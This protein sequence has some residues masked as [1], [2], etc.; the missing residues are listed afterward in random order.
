[1]KFYV[2]QFLQANGILHSY[3]RKG[4]P[5][6]NAPI[7]AFHSIIKREKLNRLVLKTYEKAKTVIF[8]YI[9]GFYNRRR[10]HR[11]I[12]YMT[13]YEVHYSKKEIL[14]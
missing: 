7:E 8:K 12:N 4:I 13:P 2:E 11:S 6:D 3:S 1:M 9:E 5:Q 14:T 10:T